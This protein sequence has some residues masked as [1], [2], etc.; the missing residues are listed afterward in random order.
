ML[1]AREVVITRE[2]EIRGEELPVEVLVLLPRRPLS[3][4]PYRVPVRTE[5]HVGLE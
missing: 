5:D 3:A 4:F 2:E 1:L